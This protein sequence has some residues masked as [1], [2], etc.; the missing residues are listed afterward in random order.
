[1]QNFYYLLNHLLSILI[2]KKKIA[3]IFLSVLTISCSKKSI[4]NDTPNLVL[5]DTVAKPIPKPVA[6]NTGDVVGKVIV[7][8]QGWFSGYNDSSPNGNWSHYTSSGTPSSTNISIVSWPDMRGYTTSYQTGFANLGNGQPAKLFSSW[9]QQTVNEHFLSMQRAGIDG[10]ALQRFGS[11]LTPGSTR[12]SQVDGI[13]TK[14]MSAAQTYGRKFYVMY[15]C[16]A[17]DAVQ[18]DWTNTVI[19]SLHL[20]SSSSYAQQNGKPVVCFWGVGDPGRGTPDEWATTINWFK[21]QGCYV[22]GGVLHT[23]TGD[24][25]NAAAYNACN[26]IMP[27]IVGAISNI[28]QADAYYTNHTIPDMA[29]C[30]AHGMDYQQA[31]APGTLGNHYRLHGNLMWEQFYNA[32]RGHVQGI[33]ISMFDEFNEGNQIAKTAENAAMIP[34][35]ATGAVAVTL[36][37]DGTVCSSDYYIRLTGDGTKMLKGTIVLTATRPTPPILS[38]PTNLTSKVLSSTSVQISWSGVTGAPVYNLKRSTTA[39]GPYA[40][41][42]AEI[43]GTTY[44]DTGLS[45]NTN[46]YYMVTSGYYNS[47]E[48]INSSQVNAKTNP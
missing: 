46:Y 23:W 8:Y 39:G 32:I 29:Y 16:K 42:A 48:S 27:W 41:V 33:Y 25:A 7:G 40:T 6:S 20:T 13:A 28:S 24:T 44:I 3:L 36:D 26:M 38:A 45:A 18:A 4:K 1:M 47:C 10:A 37:E 15:D 30:A 2:M 21:A 5:T 9:D 31:V 19:A 14:V 12:K 11:W 34:T 17:T 22:I 43:T 35:D